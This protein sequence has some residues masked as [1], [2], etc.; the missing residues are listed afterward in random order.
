MNNI[1]QTIRH[2]ARAATV[3]LLALL[4]AQTA[5]AQ[6]DIPEVSTV[7]GFA[8]AFND[9]TVSVINVTDNI[10]GVGDLS[11]G[12]DLT[13]NL[14]G[15]TISGDELNFDVGPNGS[16]TINGGGNVGNIISGDAD[17][18]AIIN[19]GTVT[20][21]NV[22]ITTN[23]DFAI[24]GFGTLNIGNNVSF[25]GWT[26]MPFDTPNVNNTG[27]Y[28][29][30]V[31][32]TVTVGGTPHYFENSDIAF[33]YIVSHPDNDDFSL[34]GDTYTIK[35]A[36]GWDFFCD[37]LENGETFSGKTVELANDI[38]V[39]RMAGLEGHEFQDR[40]AHGGIGRP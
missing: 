4:A 23:F 10:T 36:T 13:I 39:T 30:T 21:R 2:T 32:A 24:G 15:H 20:L 8:E 26:G 9:P 29:G 14:N 7:S 12:R 28:S 40:H 1:I 16:L 27:H 3:L 11:L 34:S 35:S 25:N 37:M 17:E 33:A 31:V 18:P 22:N 6:E 5:G 38:T 19:S